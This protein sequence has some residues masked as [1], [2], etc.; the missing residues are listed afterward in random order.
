[1]NWISVAG[2]MPERE[3]MVLVYASQATRFAIREGL[4]WWDPYRHAYLNADGVTHW[5]PL[6]SPP[7]PQD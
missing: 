5:M 6:P 4:D 2:E 1:M 3:K 7:E